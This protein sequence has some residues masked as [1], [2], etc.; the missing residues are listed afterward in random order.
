[1]LSLALHR[2]L[3]GT[4]V[5]LH[6]SFFPYFFF[7]LGGGKGTSRYKTWFLSM[8]N[9]YTFYFFFVTKDLG[10]PK[11]FV[12]SQENAGGAQTH[13]Q[14]LTTLKNSYTYHLFFNIRYCGFLSPHL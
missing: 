6:S 10:N 9:D 8:T 3:A 2:S 13:M 1:M 11:N 14:K 5:T 4:E 7:F 12:Y